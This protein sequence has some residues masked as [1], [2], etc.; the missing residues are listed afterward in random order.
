[1]NSA[2]E[3]LLFIWVTSA[4]GPGESHAVTDEQMAIAVN[5]GRHHAL[6]GAVFLAGSML[7]QPSPR[8]ARCHDIV[9]VRHAAPGSRPLQR[10]LRQV[11]AALREAAGPTIARTGRHHHG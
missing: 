5:T 4:F 10:A 2:G 11:A 3:R 6:C 1:M 9:H 8:C 7:T